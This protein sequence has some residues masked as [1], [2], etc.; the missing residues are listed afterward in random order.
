MMNNK[1]SEAKQG[2]ET[3][4]P[5]FYSANKKNVYITEPMINKKAALIMEYLNMNDMKKSFSALIDHGQGTTQ[6][7]VLNDDK[8][9]E[10]LTNAINEMQQNAIN[11]VRNERSKEL[12]HF[13]VKDMLEQAYFNS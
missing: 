8:S 1:D 11:K 12:K 13:F 7:S 5:E 6:I 4:N 3:I 10:A 9:I 2:V